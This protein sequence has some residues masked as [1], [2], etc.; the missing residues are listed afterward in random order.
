MEKLQLQR[1]FTLVILCLPH[2]EFSPVAIA[3]YRI[4]GFRENT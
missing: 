1:R 4:A 3:G 2:L